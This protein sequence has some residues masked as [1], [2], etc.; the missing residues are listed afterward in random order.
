MYIN[1]NLLR[2]AVFKVARVR[3]PPG[4]L[5][6]NKLQQVIYGRRAQ[7]NSAFHPSGVGK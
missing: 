2:L 5:T 4:P 3:F 7:A 1:Q 6:S